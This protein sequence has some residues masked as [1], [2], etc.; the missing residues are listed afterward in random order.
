MGHSLG[1]CSTACSRRNSCACRDLRHVSGRDKRS[2]AGW[3]AGGADG[4]RE[5]LDNFWQRVSQAAA[6]SPLQRSPR[7]WLMGRWTLDT[8]PGYLNMDLM[9]RVFLASRSQSHGLQS[10]AWYSG[11]SH[12]FRP[13]GQI[14]HQALRDRH[15][16]P[17]RPWTSLPQRRDYP[18][19]PLASACLPTMCQ[20]VEI[21]G[22]PSWDGGYASNP[23]IT[24]LVRESD[25]HDTILVRINRERLEPPRSASNSESA[26]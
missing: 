7:D 9:S 25:A 24:P 5:A 2:G 14:T 21:G 1:A 26:Q 11:R 3:T 22:E 20:A 16:G 19:V 6:L 15:K 23:T 12:R 18:D 4:A 10:V 8:S 13:F 17:N